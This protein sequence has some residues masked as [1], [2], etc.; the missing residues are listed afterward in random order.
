L[1]LARE[2]PWFIMRLAGQ[3]QYRRSRL[4]SN[5]RPRTYAMTIDPFV[6]SRRSGICLAILTAIAS[7][8][9]FSMLSPDVDCGSQHWTCRTLAGIGVVSVAFG[10][11]YALLLTAAAILFAWALHCAFSRIGQIEPSSKALPV[12]VSL[13]LLHVAGFGILDV[14]GF[15]PLGWQWWL[16]A[17]GAFAVPVQADA[18]YI[19][20]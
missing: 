11:G 17:L 4:N 3:A 2:A 7:F 9:W 1:H 15:L 8:F 18:V 20:R 19:F 13:T 5:V 6:P 10:I 14:V 16:G 12:A